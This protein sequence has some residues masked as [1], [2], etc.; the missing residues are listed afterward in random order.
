MDANVPPAKMSKNNYPAYFIPELAH[1]IAMCDEKLPFVDLA[2]ELTKRKITHTGLQTEANSTSLVLKLLTLPRPENKSQNNE[3]SN[4]SKNLPTIEKVV[5]EALTKRLLSI[6]LRTQYKSNNNNNFWMAELI[7]YETPLKSK[8]HREQSQRRPV[9]F[10]Y[11]LGISESVDKTVDSLLED[12]SRIVYLYCLVHDFA[13]QFKNGMKSYSLKYIS[14]SHSFLFLFTDMNLKNN[15]S[16]KS[17]SYT[18][19]L[20]GYGPN[21]EVTVNV[22]WCTKSKEFKLVFN[23]GNSAINAH[24]MMQEQLQSHLNRHHNLSQIVHLLHETYQPLSSIAKLPII[25]QLG[26][27]VS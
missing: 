14:V 21:R 12:W 25:P 18:N 9:Y 22:F 23:G 7:F 10:Q 15:I 24:S 16:I 19:L 5:W 3:G 13:E 1:V 11:E 4:R 20:I 26:I 2:K 6:S 27:K 8:H 17:Y